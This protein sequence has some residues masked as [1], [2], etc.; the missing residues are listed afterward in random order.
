MRRLIYLDSKQHGLMMGS[1]PNSWLMKTRNLLLVSFLLCASVLAPL[2][3]APTVWTGSLTNFSKL[4]F[5]NP[6]LAASQDR[7]TSN[8]WLTRGSS[9]GLF[10]ARTESFFT[11]FSSPAGTEWANGSLANYASLSY[12]DWNSWAKG[13]NAGPSSTVGVNAVLHL[14]ADDIYLSIRFTS[15][16]GGGTG[17]GFSYQRSTPT[18]VPEPS[19]LMFLTL[20]ASVAFACRR[21]RRG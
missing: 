5:A 9:Q 3:A 7:L 19:A 6:S 20:G 13:V 14:I 15:W 16:S 4:D 18:V 17:G 1:N 21:G 2:D 8:V 12:T 11:H 10:N